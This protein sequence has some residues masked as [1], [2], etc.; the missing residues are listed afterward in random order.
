MRWKFV[1]IS[2]LVIAVLLPAAGYLFLRTRDF[3]RYKDVIAN[4]VKDA[5]GRE[6]SLEGDVDLQISFWPAL[7]VTNVAL[8]NTPWGSQPEMIRI[9][10]LEARLSLLRLLMGSV[11]LKQMAMLGVDLVLETDAA[12]LGNWEFNPA[13]GS[14]QYNLWTFKQLDVRDIRIEDLRL[15]FHNGETG[16]KMRLTI[17]S[18]N[19]SKDDSKKVLAIDLEGEFNKQK[20]ALSGQ[21]GLISD[22]FARKQFPVDLSGQIASAAIKVRGAVSDV[23]ELK[24]IDLEIHASGKNLAEVAS[25]A[26]ISVVNTDAFDVKGHIE[27]SA[28]TLALKEAKGNFSIKGVE[29][30]VDGSIGEIFSLDD[31]DLQI[32][33]SGG[34][35]SEVGPVIEQD[36]PETGPFTLSGRL[37]GSAR[38][39][40]LRTHAARRPTT[41]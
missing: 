6:L 10:R 37:T 12:G 11:D 13:E 23:V 34:N 19:A 14:S 32:K 30:D 35:L 17:S 33:A 15:L 39:S 40:R 1:A 24:G 18:L 2:L 21:T 5:T 7:V 36:L 41:V 27:G 9:H 3:N 25:T 38:R 26:G 22:L 8:A 16:S 29:I 31:I 28:A 4:A 20:V